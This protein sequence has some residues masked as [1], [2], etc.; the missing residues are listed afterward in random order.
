RGVSRPDS[1]RRAGRLPFPVASLTGQSAKGGAVDL[2]DTPDQAA[3]RAQVRSWL[4]EHKSE[5]PVLSG[6]GALQDEEE[7]IAARRVWQ[8]K[9]AEGGLAGLTWP[10]EYGGQ[11]LGPIEQVTANQEIA[12]AGVPGILDG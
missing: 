2:D 3:F 9:L 1:A 12:R 7:I 4:E 11:G 5:A 10:K 6:P 8:G